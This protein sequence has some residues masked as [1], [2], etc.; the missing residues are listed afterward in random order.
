LEVFG[1]RMLRIEFGPNR[2][3]QLEAG[4]FRSEKLHDF[5][6]APKDMTSKRRRNRWNV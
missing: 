5:Y 6:P 3:K 2:K 4:N 1:V